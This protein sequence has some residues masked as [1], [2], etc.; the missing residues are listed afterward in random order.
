MTSKKIHLRLKLRK[1]IGL[2]F[3]V[4]LKEYADRAFLTASGVRYQLA[5]RKLIGYYIRRKWWILPPE[6]YEELGIYP[7]FGEVDKNAGR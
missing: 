2:E 7:Q 1:R 6:Y 5:T 4:P 3:C